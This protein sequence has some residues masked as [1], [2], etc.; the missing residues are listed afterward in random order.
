MLSNLYNICLYIDKETLNNIGKKIS[1]I[2]GKYFSN[3]TGGVVLTLLIAVILFSFI[4]SSR[5]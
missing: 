5:R 3:I 4:G 1:H 2:V